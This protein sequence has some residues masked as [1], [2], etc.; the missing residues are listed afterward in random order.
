MTVPSWATSV[1][2]AED[3]LIARLAAQVLAGE[4]QR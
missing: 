3:G 1:E 2:P 4:G